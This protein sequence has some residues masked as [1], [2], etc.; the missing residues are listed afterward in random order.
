[1]ICPRCKSEID[2]P[3]A[4]VRHSYRVKKTGNVIKPDAMHPSCADQ[5]AAEKTG[6]E[7]VVA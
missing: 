3:E 2:P 1:M 5:Y 6:L 7:K 4:A